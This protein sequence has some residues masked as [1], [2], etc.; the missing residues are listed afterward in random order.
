MFLTYSFKCKTAP[1]DIG[2]GFANTQP[3]SCAGSFCSFDEFQI[4]EAV[5][6]GQFIDGIT[7]S[8]V[9]GYIGCD[10]S[11][12]FQFIKKFGGPTTSGK[13]AGPDYLSPA[14]SFGLFGKGPHNS[15][16]IFRM[17]K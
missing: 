14:H 13:P 12:L 4:E 6:V 17:S 11:R 3:G 8:T 1:T 9:K 15:F 2:L 10:K 16:M 7:Q 5:F